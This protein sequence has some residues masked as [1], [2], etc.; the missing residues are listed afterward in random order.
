MIESEHPACGRVGR[1][2]TKRRRPR[3]GARTASTDPSQER[4]RH[5]ISV[6][7]ARG[8]H[9]IDRVP[10]QCRI[11]RRSRRADLQA[12]G[13]PQRHRLL[14]RKVRLRVQAALRGR[15]ELHRGDQ[16]P[17]RRS[18]GHQGHDPGLGRAR[19]NGRRGFAGS[20]EGK[21]RRRLGSGRPRRRRGANV[22]VGG[23][24]HSVTLQPLSAS[25][26][27]GT[28]VSVGIEEFELS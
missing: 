18:V 26:I 11:Q 9:G 3:E 4:T 12:E 21:I 16:E 22:L 15:A 7:R 20:A 8:R 2:G 28:G 1:A 25:G 23:G 19:A 13:R 6:R 27:V 24:R 10:R 14:L 17:R 5:E